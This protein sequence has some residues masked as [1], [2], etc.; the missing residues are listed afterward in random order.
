MKKIINEQL[1]IGRTSPVKARFYN[2]RKFTY[3]LHLHE[4]YEIIYIRHGSGQCL[5]GNTLSPFTD[6]SLFLFGSGLPHCMRNDKRYD[7]DSSLHVCGTIVQFEKDFM[8]YAFSNYIPFS[9]INGLLKNAGGGIRFTVPKNSMTEELANRI[10]E[11]ENAELIIDVLQLLHSL[12]LLK[13]RKIIADPG[14]P[15]INSGMKDRKLEKV[16]DFI[17]KNYTQKLSLGDIAAFTAMNPS[18]FCRYFK[19]NMG[20]TLM[21][22]I[23]KLRVDHACRLL[24]TEKLN[25]SQ[26]CLECG[27]DTIS[28]FNRYF[29]KLTGYTPK[30]FRDITE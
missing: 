13:N 23:L 2:Y 6:G 4:E 15:V 3:P 9:N 10:P 28:H 8:Q 26:V 25:I 29:K 19:E 24:A 1:Y 12:T 18:A 30:E 5:V 7:T 27:F 16:I 11:D 20:R 14:L 17:S 21:Q 22:Y